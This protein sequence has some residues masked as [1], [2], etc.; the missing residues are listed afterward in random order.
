MTSKPL[1]G[2]TSTSTASLS[3]RAPRS[4]VVADVMPRCLRLLLVDD[5]E[6]TLELMQAAL[7]ESGFDVRIAVAV[8]EAV[9]IASSWRP[10]VAV[11][12]LRRPDA[13]DPTGRALC[14][15]LREHG[16][17]L[18]LV[19]SSLTEPELVRA[20]REAG[21]DGHV[22]KT[23]GLTAFARRVEDLVA[24]SLGGSLSLPLQPPELE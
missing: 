19:A 10:D 23:R 9:A 20:C 5:S 11:I 4:S 15:V 22:S 2:V 3:P 21:A 14:A 6:V 7:K 8:S 17:R 18:T 16:V 13:L 1:S 12:D 24:R